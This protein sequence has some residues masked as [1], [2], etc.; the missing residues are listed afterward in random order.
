MSL[1]YRAESRTPRPMDDAQDVGDDFPVKY[2]GLWEYLTTLTFPDGKPRQ[3]AT[4]MLTM[5][6]G[7]FKGCLN[8]RANGRSAWVS[9]RSPAGVFSLMEE[10]LQEDTLEWRKNQ[11]WKKGR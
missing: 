2:P 10:R 5:D 3:T 11:T 8:D 9:S 4:F 1:I 7:S 6:D